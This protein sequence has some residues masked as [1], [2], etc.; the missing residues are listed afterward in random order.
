M[1]FEEI[2]VERFTSSYLWILGKDS[3]SNL[4]MEYF[5]VS[6]IFFKGHFSTKKSFGGR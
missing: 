1:H 4:T 2:F 5:L 3:V 6:K